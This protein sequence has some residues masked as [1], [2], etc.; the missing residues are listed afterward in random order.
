M[1]TVRIILE[2]NEEGCKPARYID[3]VLNV[4]IEKLQWSAVCW[5]LRGWIRELEENWDRWIR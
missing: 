3:H 2:Y 5:R 4:P 1:N